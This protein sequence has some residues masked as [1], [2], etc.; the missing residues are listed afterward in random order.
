[1]HRRNQ[2]L[3]WFSLSQQAL[4]DA[5]DS[6]ARTTPRQPPFVRRPSPR[7]P[8]TMPSA[9]LDLLALFVWLVAA[10]CARVPQF[11]QA[12]TNPVPLARAC[13]SVNG[14]VNVASHILPFW[15]SWHLPA[16]NPSRPASQL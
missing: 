5:Q 16:G 4:C 3:P 10:A 7:E 9:R 2:A 13:E 12:L 1:L 14:T 8:I 6:L 15:D 11:P